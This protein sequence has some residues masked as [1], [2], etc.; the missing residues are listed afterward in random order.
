MPSSH[1]KVVDFF[2][3]CSKTSKLI[4]IIFEKK[5]NGIY[6][7][8]CKKVRENK[9][10]MLNKKSQDDEEYQSLTER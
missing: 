2:P 8:L 5:Y 1:N 10:L 3:T 6:V 9:T 7:E 4:K